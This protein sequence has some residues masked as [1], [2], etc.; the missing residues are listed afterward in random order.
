MLFSPSLYNRQH[1][2]ILFRY[3]N[4]GDAQCFDDSSMSCLHPLADSLEFLDISGTA[5]TERGF[6]YIR[7]FSKLRFLNI[8]RLKV[9]DRCHKCLEEA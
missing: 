1:F 7:L 4:V 2:K 9:G 3:I 6:G 5:V 8:S